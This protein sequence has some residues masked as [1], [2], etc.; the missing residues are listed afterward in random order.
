MH[1]VYYWMVR[2]NN[3][4]DKTIR[5]KDKNGRGMSCKIERRN[6]YLKLIKALFMYE[7][8]E[9]AI[10]REALSRM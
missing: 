5:E 10:S 3:G 2:D 7:E 1:V 9:R 4:K 8:R 6:Q